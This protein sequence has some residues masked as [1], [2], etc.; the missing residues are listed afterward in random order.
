MKLNH[1]CDDCFKHGAGGFVTL[2]T[3]A[4]VHDTYGPQSAA[5]RAHAMGHSTAT[6][7][8]EAARAAGVKYLILTHIRAS[9]FVDPDA[10]VAEAKSEFGGPVKAAKDLDIVDF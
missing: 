3:L 5:E 7:A 6:E 8:G 9:R 4:L 10:L 2:D 1:L